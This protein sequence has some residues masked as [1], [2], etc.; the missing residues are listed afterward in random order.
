MAALPLVV[1]PLADATFLVMAALLLMATALADATFLVM[2]GTPP[3]ATQRTYAT[4]SPFAQML[5]PYSVNCEE[6]KRHGN[7]GTYT[8]LDCCA[9]RRTMTM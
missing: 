2:T 6:R 1:T 5:P 8:A 7:D 4:P 9:S 3:V